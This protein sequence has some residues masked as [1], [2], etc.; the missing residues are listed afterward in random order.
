MKNII[1]ILL[2]G[3]LTLNAQMFNLKQGW[4]LVG[5]VEDIDKLNAFTT[6]CVGSMHTYDG[7]KWNVYPEGDLTKISQGEGFWVYS[8]KDCNIDAS[9]ETQTF[10][11]RSFYTTQCATC[12]GNNGE[13]SRFRAIKDNTKDWYLSKLTPFRI[14]DITS[15]P[16]MSG[17]LNGFDENNLDQLTTFLATLGK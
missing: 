4:G 12:H 2:L 16:V 17:I 8:K 9:K 14:G 10:N 13:G 1:L 3:A 7:S 11:S 15:P 6:E 5:A